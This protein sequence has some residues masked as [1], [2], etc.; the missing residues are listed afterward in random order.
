M[1]PVL[2]KGGLELN[3]PLYEYRC[4]NCEKDFE[5]LVL[6]SDEEVNCP[7]CGSGNG[8]LEKLFSAFGFKSKNSIASSTATVSSG[9]GCT[10]VGCGCSA[11]H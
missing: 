11:K 3:M 2:L 5:T 9:C 8:N 10:P 7:Q 1:I 4:L 6:D